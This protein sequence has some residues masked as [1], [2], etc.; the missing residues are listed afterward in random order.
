M[1]LYLYFILN[2]AIN[3]AGYKEMACKMKWNPKE[4]VLLLT[5]SS[6]ITCVDRHFANYQRCHAILSPRI[7][8]GIVSCLVSSFGW[9]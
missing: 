9:C 6:P 7:I 2:P 5:E 1:I 3:L 8:S 4:R